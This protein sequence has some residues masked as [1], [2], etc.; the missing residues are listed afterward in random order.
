MPSIFLCYRRE[1]AAAHAGRLHDALARSFGPNSLFMDIDGIEPGE[2]FDEALKNTLNR[3]DVVL[4]VIGPQWCEVRD[5][6]GLRRIDDVD[7][8]VRL[9]VATA[10]ARG[11]RLIPVLVGNARMPKSDTLPDDLKRLTRRQSIEITETRWAYDSERLAEAIRKAGAKSQSG[12]EIEGGGVASPSHV[13]SATTEETA[14][15]QPS[16][17]ESSEQTESQSIQSSTPRGGTEAVDDH[18]SR[19]PVD[20]TESRPAARTGSAELNRLLVWSSATA[21]VVLI[22]LVTSPI[23]RKK[24]AAPPARPI[25]VGQ[26]EI[27]FQDRSP[28]K[29]LDA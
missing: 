10:L 24:S 21:V 23:W 28:H 1:D 12:V 27:A 22:V 9:E 20:K 8:Y 4:V 3:A 26:F 17:R 6:A 11:V 18:L 13:V 29:R 16:T 2:D 19:I 25:S 7:D 14:S 5:E 15:A